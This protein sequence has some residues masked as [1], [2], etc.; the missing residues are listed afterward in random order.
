MRMIYEVQHGFR[1]ACLGGALF[2]LGGTVACKDV[3]TADVT[4]TWI[5]HDSSRQVLP[6]E[7]Q[8]AAPRI[9]LSLDGTFSASDLPG[10]FYFPGRRDARLESGSGDWKLVSRDGEQQIQL[11]FRAIADW[12]TK[13]LPFGDQLD[14]SRGWSQIEISYFLGDP[15]E[16]KEIAFTEY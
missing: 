16:G 14:V 15:D 10:F 13:D 2:L 5:M 8:K 12:N 1:L 6:N 7:L 4:G 3:Q 11:T 9:V